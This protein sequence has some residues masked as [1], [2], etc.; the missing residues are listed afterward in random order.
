MT[1]QV[2]TLSEGA[3]SRPDT[4]AE[5]E[6]SGFFYWVSLLLTLRCSL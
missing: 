5:S 2:M 4:G 6:F 3:V 1:A